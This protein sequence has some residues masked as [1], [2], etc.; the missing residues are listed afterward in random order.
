ML[1]AVVVLDWLGLHVEL[2][3]SVGLGVG[4]GLEVVAAVG[5]PVKVCVALGEVDTLG[6]AAWLGVAVVDAVPCMTLNEVADP[7]CVVHRTVPVALEVVRGHATVAT[8]PAEN[9]TTVMHGMNWQ[10]RES[11]RR[12]TCGVSRPGGRVTQGPIK[13]RKQRRG[14][15][16]ARDGARGDE[17]DRRA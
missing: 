15:Q 17:A 1:V 3:V 14:W 13:P 9:K 4:V 12:R 10:A 16:D 7:N 5:E 8:P 2:G 11:P 6:D